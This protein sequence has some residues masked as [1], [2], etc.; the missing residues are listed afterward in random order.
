MGTNNAVLTPKK[1]NSIEKTLKKHGIHLN[2]IFLKLYFC[3]HPI[4]CV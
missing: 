4:F 2:Y 1:K 3:Y